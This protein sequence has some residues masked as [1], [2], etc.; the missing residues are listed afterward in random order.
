MPPIKMNNKAMRH[1]VI[2]SNAGI[3]VP[4][5]AD[6]N[7]SWRPGATMA[8]TVPINLT[9]GKEAALAARANAEGVNVQKFRSEFN[10]GA[11]AENAT[12]PG[13]AR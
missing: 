2:F 3:F 5:V 9:T 10:L 11:L 13:G 12:R 4:T 7:A 8:V 1:I 6:V